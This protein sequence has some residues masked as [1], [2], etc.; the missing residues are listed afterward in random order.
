MLKRYIQYFVAGLIV[1]GLAAC[2]TAS[3]TKSSSGGPDINS[4]ETEEYDGPKARI[5]VADFEDKTTAGGQYNANFGRGLN[6]MLINALFH[7]NRFIVLERDKLNVLM[8]EQNLASTGRMKRGSSPESGHLE[9]AEILVTAA[10]TAFDPGNS[11]GD[12]SINNLIKGNLGSLL[13]GVQRA[14]ISMDIRLIDTRRGRVL[15]TTSVDGTATSFSGG[16]SIIGGP[17]GG[18]LG[19]Y[20]KTPMDSAIREMLKKACDEISAQTPKKYFHFPANS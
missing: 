9:G 1:F 16:V 10:I 4:A 3:V 5:A 17:M 15:A 6:D 12:A 14:H 11:G 2:S 19:Q 7:T 20:A 8:T 18:S 13:G